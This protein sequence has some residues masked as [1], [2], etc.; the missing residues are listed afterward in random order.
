MYVGLTDWGI[1]QVALDVAVALIVGTILYRKWRKKKH[2]KTNASAP[3]QKDKTDTVEA[4]ME[5]KTLH[6]C[7]SCNAQFEKPWKEIVYTSNPAKE[8]LIC[9]SCKNPLNSKLTET[10]QTPTLGQHETSMEKPSISNGPTEIDFEENPPKQYKYNLT[11]EVDK[12]GPIMKK[13]SEKS[14]NP[15]AT[16]LSA[17]NS[18][19]ID[20][21]SEKSLS[22]QKLK[23]KGEIT[24][25]NEQND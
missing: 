18:F 12:L 1:F 15:H 20:I 14:L 21:T 17:E 23:E 10:P 3:S 16:A 22:F 5:P 25:W 9:P 13:L 24:D 8:R 7:P 4:P 2:L 6:R 11:V 19:C